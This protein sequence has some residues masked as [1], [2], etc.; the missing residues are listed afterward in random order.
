MINYHGLYY[1]CITDQVEILD[2]LLSDPRVDIND[3]Y[4]EH[5]FETSLMGYASHDGNSKVVKRLLYYIEQN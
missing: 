1:S 4:I 5:Y 3:H 2:L